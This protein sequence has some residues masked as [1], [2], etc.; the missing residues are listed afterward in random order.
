MLYSYKLKYRSNILFS[1]IYRYS[2]RIIFFQN[3]V[4]F[5]YFD[6]K[7]RKRDALE[8]AS[9]FI[10]I[11]ALFR[12]QQSVLNADHCIALEEN[13]QR[14]ITVTVDIGRAVRLIVFA[15]QFQNPVHAIT[16]H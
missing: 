7:I 15:V 5:R 10:V 11:S 4:S 9:L 8:R 14:R 6:I 13:I 1:A 2:S 16:Q 12:R 3:F